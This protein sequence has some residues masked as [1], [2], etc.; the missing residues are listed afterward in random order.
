MECWD[1]VPSYKVE[2]IPLVDRGPKTKGRE[3]LGGG[4]ESD[5]KIILTFSR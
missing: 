1:S 4:G 5:L 3:Y 2:A